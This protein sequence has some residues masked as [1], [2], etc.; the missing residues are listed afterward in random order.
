MNSKP[1]PP[2]PRRAG[3]CRGADV[4]LFVS[5]TA[6]ELQALFI[7]SSQFCNLSSQGFHREITSKVKV[8]WFPVVTARGGTVSPSPCI[9]IGFYSILSAFK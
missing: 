8:S 4:A 3:L 1:P 2:P 5:A 7:K 6:D 9:H